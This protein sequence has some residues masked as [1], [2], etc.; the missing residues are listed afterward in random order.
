MLTGTLR[1]PD[2]NWRCALVRDGHRACYLGPLKDG[3]AHG[4]CTS[5]EARVGAFHARSCRETTHGVCV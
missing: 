4:A 2:L 5:I 3:G 1:V